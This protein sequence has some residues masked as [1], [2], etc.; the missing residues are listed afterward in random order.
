[1]AL[2]VVG[3]KLVLEGG[4]GF[5]SQLGKIDAGI[6]NLGASAKGASTTWNSAASQIASAAA[7]A[8]GGIE[9]V[10]PAASGAGSGL[11]NLNDKAEQS[12]GVLGRLAGGLGTAATAAA[13]LAAITGGA[14]LAGLGGAAAAGL[15]F[16]NSM[17]QA[18]ARINAFTK[19]A[20]AT[21]QILA[22]VA[23]RASKTPFAFEEMASAAAALGPSAKSSGMELEDLIAQAE[24]LAASNPAEGLEGAA[25]AIKEAIS[26]DFTSA[27]ER[28]NLSRSYINQLKDEGVPAM[29]ALSMAMQQAGYDADLVTSLA[30][31]M[32]GRWSTLK[33]TF[34][35]LA[36][37]VTQPI[38][39]ALSSSLG[40]VNEKLAAAGPQLTGV[41]TLIGEKIAPYAA[42]AAEGIATLAAKG[43]ELA[44]GLASGEIT[45]GS[46]GSKL[47]SFAGEAIPGMLAGLQEAGQ[48]L[49]GWAQEQAPGWASSLAE[50]GGKLAGWVQENVPGMLAGLL[51]A[52]NQM[53][54]WVLDSLPAWGSALAEMGYKLYTWVLE[55][56]PNLG[57]ALGNVAAVL[58]AKTGEFIAIVVPKLLELGS[59]LVVW[60]ATEVLPK[61]PGELVKVGAALLT[62]IGNF[63][64]Q[65]APELGKLG[66]QF[67]TWVGTEVIPKLP[68][69]LAKIGTGIVTGITGF[70]GSVN[71]EAGKVGQAIIDGITGALSRGAG[72]IKE[73][74]QQAAQ[75]ALDAAKSLLGISSPSRA[76]YTQVG[77]PIGQGMALGILSQLSSVRDAAA[78]LGDEAL[79]TLS[80]IAEE[81]QKR[82]SEALGGRIGLTRGLLGGLQQQE[83]DT[84]GV[85]AAQKKLNDLR[86][87]AVADA[88]EGAAKAAEI[89]QE[90]AQKAADIRADA[91]EK[92]AEAARKQADLAAELGRARYTAANNID[93]K[94][95]EDAAERVVELER[96]IAEAQADRSSG[97]ADANARAAAIEA[98]TQ[99][100]V[101]EA[102]A[103]VQAAAAANRAAQERAQRELDAATQTRDTRRRLLADAQTQTQELAKTD[104]VAARDFYAARSQQIDGLLKLQQEYE[105]ADGADRRNNLAWQ[106]H[107]LKDAQA[108]ET[109]QLR[110]GLQ[111]R[112]AELA[113]AAAQGKPTGNAL[114]DGM[115]AG[116]RERQAALG[117]ALLAT[118]QQ[119]LGAAKAELGIRSPSLVFNQQVGQPIINGI[120][121]GVQAQ[122]PALTTAMQG[123]GMGTV[124]PVLQ[125]V[126]RSSTSI[127][128]GHSFAIDAR[129]AQRGVGGEI[130]RAISSALRT[131]TGRAETIRRMT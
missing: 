20:G 2:P 36:G 69:E 75:N 8:A 57:T 68:G 90:G 56:L 28:F 112:A 19:D 107:V 44:A 99:A 66:L 4:P 37:T 34:T 10:A 50:L 121:A 125:G 63:I 79:S 111:A 18:R 24:I 67:I 96:A 21:E 49:L 92:D 114:I 127:N 59:K 43:I 108:L 123:V 73:A 17:E 76:F 27:I 1:M 85:D 45:I 102:Q 72:A 61:L 39:D 88:Q 55:N 60:V 129:G 48:R 65:V 109:E 116:V 98:E 70:I 13:G 14:I 64:A 47:A 30:G 54:A 26:G 83:Q 95:R 7:K 5:L 128:N 40:V 130:E 93:P 97:A 42:A 118:L 80:G 124:R 35:T 51:D 131:R 74:A 32:E 41:A 71:T 106:L 3:V 126:S 110:Q 94:K 122:M 113:N 9:K 84:A 6:K 29:E 16:N 52:R 86:A 77:E 38:F 11:A 103:S 58:L 87:Q 81:A 12:T 120:I 33:D 53:V 101:A 117:A 31:T 46:L 23:D 22:M 104:A 62:G 78:A 119:T 91:R 105:L 25:F 115:I 89:E 100:K 15:G 82:I